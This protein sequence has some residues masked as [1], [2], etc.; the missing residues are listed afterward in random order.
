VVY[1]IMKSLLTVNIL[2]MAIGSSALAPSPYTVS[3]GNETNF[4]DLISSAAYYR[5]ASV[6]DNI[7]L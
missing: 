4:P 2:V 3:V 6:G 7:L 1:L 5:F